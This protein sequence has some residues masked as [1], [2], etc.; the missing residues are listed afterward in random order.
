MSSFQ[1]P[2][3]FLINL[4]FKVKVLVTVT[5]PAYLLIGIF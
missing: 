5:S 2:G 4:F 3:N 1:E